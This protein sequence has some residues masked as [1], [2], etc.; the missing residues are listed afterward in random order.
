[1]TKAIDKVL[2]C[3]AM[4][5]EEAF[6]E[7]LGYASCGGAYEPKLSAVAKEYKSSHVSKIEMIFNRLVK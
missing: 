2:S 7:S 6:L 3:M 1:M 4:T 5:A